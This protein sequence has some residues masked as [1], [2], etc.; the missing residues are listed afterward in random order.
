M[1]HAGAQ[2]T[3][4]DVM[5]QR[6]TFRLKDQ[7]DEVDVMPMLEVLP[8]SEIAPVPGAARDVLGIINLRGNV[9]A[10]ID[11]RTRFGLPTNTIDDAR[12]IQGVVQ[13]GDDRWVVVDLDPRL[14]DPCGSG[15]AAH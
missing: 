14:T 13:L 15:L 5:V 12:H 10:L 8:M 9:A 11:T 6:V 7:T 1:S 4:G 3:A 2:R